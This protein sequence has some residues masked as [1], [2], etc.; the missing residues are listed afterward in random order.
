MVKENAL[1]MVAAIAEAAN[2]M[3][4]P[5]WKEPSSLVFD[6][7]SNY[8]KPEY[9][10]LRGQAIETLTLIGVAVGRDY[11]KQIASRIIEEMLKIQANY[12]EDVDPQKQYL[13]A[14]YQR[15]CIVLKSDF[16]PYLEQILPPLFE[17]IE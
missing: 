6:I 9:K 11:F 16:V 8:T 4:I 2:R 5:F 1:A 7:L 3:F 12:L 13:L 17:L 14:G 10:Q 15:L